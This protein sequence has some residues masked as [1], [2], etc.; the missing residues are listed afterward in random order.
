MIFEADDSELESD[1]DPDAQRI[2]PGP[3]HTGSFTGD[4]EPSVLVMGKD[5]Y[6]VV[7]LG[8]DR[9]SLEEVGSWRSEDD[10][11]VPHELAVGDINSDGYGDM[12]SLDAGNQNFDIFTYNKSGDMLHARDS[13]SSNPRCSQVVMDVSTPNQL[14]IT[15]LTGDGK[16]GVVMLYHD[17]VLL[18][19]Q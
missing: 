3:I 16:H 6:A 18:Y 7:R 19:P 14:I 9:R 15:D 11:S 2:P 5:G 1:R 4:G 12:V 17:R 10:R 8:G 13:R